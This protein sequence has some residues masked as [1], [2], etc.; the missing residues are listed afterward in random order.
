[1]ASAPLA[2]GTSPVS[3][4]QNSEPGNPVSTKINSSNQSDKIAFPQVMKQA[5]G[6]ADRKEG[7]DE[8]TA[9]NARGTDPR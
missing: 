2:I 8:H 4:T 6:G 5:K 9:S 3:V 1:M 7:K